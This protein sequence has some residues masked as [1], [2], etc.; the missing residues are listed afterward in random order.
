M[1]PKTP[2]PTSSTIPTTSEELMSKLMD[3]L[4]SMTQRL[5]LIEAKQTPNSPPH[6]IVALGGGVHHVAPPVAPSLQQ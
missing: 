6:T 5:D 3:Q 1:A 4:N 2:L